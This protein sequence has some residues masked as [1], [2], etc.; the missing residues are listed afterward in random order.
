VYCST[1]KHCK[2]RHRIKGGTYQQAKG[3]LNR[4]NEEYRT[5][6]TAA[7]VSIVKVVIGKKGGLISKPKENLT[8]LMKNTEHLCTAAEYL[9]TVHS[10][11]KIVIE[12][13]RGG[14]AYQ[15]AKG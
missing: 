15:Q 2:G 10:I 13:K 7:E 14:G 8:D 4:L 1:G 5:L 6:C 9:C 12:K 11:V 3:K